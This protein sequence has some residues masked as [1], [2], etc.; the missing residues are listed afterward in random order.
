[1]RCQDYFGSQPEPSHHQQ[2]SSIAAES[3]KTPRAT[4]SSSS[5]AAFV[6]GPHQRMCTSPSRESLLRDETPE[7]AR[8]YTFAG[9]D[10]CLAEEHLSTT[11]AA[12]AAAAAVRRLPLPPLGQQGG[13]QF[14]RMGGGANGN[15]LKDLAKISQFNLAR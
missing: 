13:H 11:A 12:A 1:M 4:S 14:Q 7:V 9:P 8:K 2:K 5:S 10:T 6:R 15:L 3:S